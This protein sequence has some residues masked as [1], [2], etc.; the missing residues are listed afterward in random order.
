MSDPTSPDFQ[1]FET[2]PPAGLSDLIE[3]IWFIR[4]SAATCPETQ[5]LLPDGRIEIVFNLADR[6]RHL[7]SPGE[8]H[9]QPRQLVVGPTS[10]SM[11]IEPTGEIDIVGVRIRPGAARAFFPDV[12]P[13]MRDNTADLA[14]IGNIF[15]RDLFDRLQETRAPEARSALLSHALQRAARRDRLEPRVTGACGAIHHSGGSLSVDEIVRQ[16]G[17]SARTLER[18]FLKQTGVGPKLLLMLTRF[19]HVVR[20][21]DTCG[22]LQAALDAGYF[23]QSHFIRDFQTFAGVAPSVFFGAENRMSDA[24]TSEG[25]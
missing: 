9:T 17:T 5:R 25:R 10:R 11:L 3:G 1:F 7:R 19:Q 24:F 21:A 13:T 23:D 2:R 8:A 6:F 18:L 4:S 14:D 22:L 15:A 16:T 12:L 20:R